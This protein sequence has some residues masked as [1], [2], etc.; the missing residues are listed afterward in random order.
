MGGGVGGTN[1]EL[2]LVRPI[3]LKRLLYFFQAHEILQHAAPASLTTVQF[4]KAVRYLLPLCFAAAMSFRFCKH[5]PGTET[6][7]AR[8]ISVYFPAVLPC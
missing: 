7:T 6:H 2:L 1:W 5:H 3:T 8:F 4:Q